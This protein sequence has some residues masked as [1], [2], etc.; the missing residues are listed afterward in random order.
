MPSKKSDSPLT[1]GLINQ[2]PT[3]ET[4]GFIHIFFVK[5]N[6]L[7]PKKL[8]IAPITPPITAPELAPSFPPE[9]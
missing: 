7:F 3:M 1:Q 5:N 9:I 4:L 8:L 2:T 6:Y